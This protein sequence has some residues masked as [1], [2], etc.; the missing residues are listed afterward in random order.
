MAFVRIVG[1][2]TPRLVGIVGPA[3]AKF[4]GFKVFDDEADL[5]DILLLDIVQT[6]GH[7]KVKWAVVANR[8][9]FA[10]SDCVDG[11]LGL[12]S[13]EL[14]KVDGAFFQKDIRRKHLQCGCGCGSIS[15]AVVVDGETDLGGFASVQASV[16]VAIHFGNAH[17]TEL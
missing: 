12:A 1:D 10:N 9:F 14:V 6:R 16:A 15:M 8:C 5:G 2:E 7:T 4:T 3:C 17:A 13:V 11:C